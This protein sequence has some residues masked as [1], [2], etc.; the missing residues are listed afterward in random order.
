MTQKESEVRKQ[1][2]VDKGVQEQSDF[3][4]L[5]VE[6][7]RPIVTLQDMP[8]DWLERSERREFTAVTR[9]GEFFAL[10]I[11]LF[12]SSC[13]LQQVQADFKDL[14]SGHGQRIPSSGIE[15]F[16]LEGQDASG[17]L[18]KKDVTVNQGGVQSLW[19]GISVPTDASADHYIGEWTI[20]AGSKRKQLTVRLTVAGEPLDDAGDS[21]LW[22]HSRLRW[23]NSD[24]ALDD[25][26]TLPYTP[27]TLKGMTV[28]CLGR[29]MTLDEHG[30]PESIISRFNY[31][32]DGMLEKG[33]PILE[34]RIRLVVESQHGEVE[35]K[36]KGFQIEQ[37]TDSCIG[38]IAESD[39]RTWE[40]SCQAKLE[41][42]GFVQFDV[43]LRAK[44]SVC[45]NDIRLD[46]PFVPEVA[47]Y[48]MG[49]GHKGGFLPDQLDWK[50]DPSKHQNAIWIGD[51]NA[52]LRCRLLDPD[53]QRPFVNIYYKHRPITVPDSWHNQGKGGVT[54][55]R[56]ERNVLFRAYSGERIVDRGEE[57]HFQF[58]LMITPLKTIDMLGH[59]NN[60]YYHRLEGKALMNT[61]QAAAEASGANII[62]VHHGAEAHPYIN[63]PFLEVENLKQ[64]VEEAHDK[65][66]KVKLYY[67]VRE[68][69][70]HMVELKAL[71]SLGDEIFPHPNPAVTT[72]LWQGDAAAWVREHLGDDV[73]PAW[74]H[75]FKVGKHA[76]EIDAAILTD[77]TSRM[78]NYYLEGLKWLAEQ[79]GIDGIYIDDTAYDR[80][81]MRR[82][83]K[84]LDR[85]KPG[86]LIDFHTW[87]H[88]NERAG[89]IN[90][91]ILY[92]EL[93]PYLDSLWIGEGFRYNEV[94]PEYWLVEISG[95]PFGLMGEML[96]HGNPWRGMVYGMP[97]R[98]GWFGQSPEHL[99]KLWDHFGIQEAQMLGYWHPDN[100]VHPER[101]D[102]QATVYSMPEQ[103]LIVLASWAEEPIECGLQIDW[104]KLGWNRELISIEVP[105]IP[106][107]Q[108]RLTLES[109]DRIPLQPQQGLLIVLRSNKR[110]QEE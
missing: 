88:M 101:S 99:W 20:M 9:P 11:V 60:R 53:G 58:D 70:D 61:W 105:A 74:K 41:F 109:L 106:D 59:W 52:G 18:F 78:V 24:V 46:I 77:G 26:V 23:L 17:Q 96:G 42:D 80:I 14:V 48:A 22:R 81:A 73:I 12:A 6:R 39:S 66:L 28:G 47:R 2:L 45:I 65:D 94:S 29:E 1:R 63:Y 3:Y 86:S 27:V 67:T 5:A 57:L 32:V 55:L 95:I 92:M 36:S 31:A 64:F 83:R 19:I 34:E 37:Q 100:P 16:A 82:A 50:W 104:E 79:V 7:E 108:E 56:Q 25:D 68:M 87:N 89:F 33:R 75:E 71:R 98:L 102:V 30:F 90:N 15:C 49:M 13:S 21:E 107:V 8:E 85:A 72:S 69:S 10:Q 51:V 62:N 84:V 91:A 4:L 110:Q 93:F 103:L 44:E 54:L 38:W 40:M 43:T 35:W 97:N 76:G